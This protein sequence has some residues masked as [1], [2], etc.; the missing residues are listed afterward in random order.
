ML[1]IYLLHIVDMKFI[2]Y[3]LN[4]ML[5][6]LKIYYNLFCITNLLFNLDIGC[7][8]AI[9]VC[10]YVCIYREI[11]MNK[12]IMSLSLRRSYARLS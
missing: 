9:Y 8:L 4:K 3:I 1:P 10:I 12:D 7:Q 5:Y 11:Y 6:M 2:I